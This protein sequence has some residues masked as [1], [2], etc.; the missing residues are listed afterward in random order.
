MRHEF[1]V[2]PLSI[3]SIW[4]QLIHRKVAFD[5]LTRHLAIF[6]DACFSAGRSEPPTQLREVSTQALARAQ[7]SD[8]GFSPD[9]GQNAVQDS[10]ELEK[11]IQK[12]E[13]MLAA[14][15]KSQDDLDELFNFE[16]ADP[17]KDDAADQKAKPS[18]KSSIPNICLALWGGPTMPADDQNLWS[19]RPFITLLRFSKNHLPLR[20]PRAAVTDRMTFGMP[21]GMPAALNPLP[22]WQGLGR[23]LLWRRDDC[24]RH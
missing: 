5:C 10:A 7:S 9:Q 24:P 2:H 19:G 12:L 21:K 23:E 22:C 13:E 6:Y 20:S 3:L 14:Q 11:R 18:P 4:S 8:L 15:P 17:P 1:K 16:E